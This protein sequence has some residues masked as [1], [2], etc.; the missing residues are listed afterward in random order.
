MSQDQGCPRARRAQLVSEE[1]EGEL[2]IYDQ[3]SDRMIRLNRSA[4]LVWK[5]CDGARTHDQILEHVR[6]E[7]GEVADA[8]LV[9]I[10]LDGLAGNDLLES[11]TPSRAPR[12]TRETRRRFIRRVGAVGAAAA[13]L[14]I[15]HAIA[16]PTPAFAAGST[17]TCGS[18]TCGSTCG[19]CSTSCSHSC[20]G[21][22]NSTCS[23]SCGPQACICAGACPCPCL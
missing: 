1:V 6:G 15:V 17:G 18:T 13:A 23:T 5:A 22:C 2:V 4:S 19:T 12:M 14:P 10:A 21:S 9:Q 16:A 7:I 8:D 11:D 3:R 20:D